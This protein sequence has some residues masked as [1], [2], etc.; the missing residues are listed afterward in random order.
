[1]ASA[2][3]LNDDQLKE[4][5]AAWVNW[6]AT[7]SD[8]SMDLYQNDFTP[9]PGTVESDYTIADFP[10][11]AAQAV[12]ST[13]WG[14]PV[15]VAHVARSTNTTVCEFDADPTGF[16]AQIIYGYLIFDQFGVYRYG[17]RFATP[18]TIEP[19]DTLKVTAIMRQAV[20]PS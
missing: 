7:G 13:T 17:E 3:D 5:L 18:K 10:G 8:W 4:M 15:A 20:F 11:Y 12:V 6:V 16:V 2:W 14:A 9:V 19:S 1:M